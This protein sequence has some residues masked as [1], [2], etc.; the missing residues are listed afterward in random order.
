MQQ[1][2]AQ[3]E[4]IELRIA[5]EVTNAAL[6]IESIDERVDAARAAREL[7][8]EQ[9]DAEQRKFEVG[10]ST[11]FFVVQA[12]RDLAAARD[13][14]LRAILDYQNAVI[15]FERVQQTSLSRAGISIVGGG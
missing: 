15:E 13:T 3:I 11:N 10:T 6:Q 8:L 14:E 4:Q 2:R 1:T 5:A 7:A 9:L 12:Q